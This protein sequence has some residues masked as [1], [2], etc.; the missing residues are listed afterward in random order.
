MLGHRGN[1]S[2]ARSDGARNFKCGRRVYPRFR[3]GFCWLQQRDNGLNATT[4]QQRQADII[5]GRRIDA[6]VAVTITAAAC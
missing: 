1:C 5:S 3:Q 2:C 4:P 6:R